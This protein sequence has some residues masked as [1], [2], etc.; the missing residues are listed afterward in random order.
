M[1]MFKLEIVSVDGVA[2]NTL[3]ISSL[4]VFLPRIMAK[5]PRTPLKAIENLA[6]V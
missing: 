6:F 1:L 4:L 5:G 3:N 2:R